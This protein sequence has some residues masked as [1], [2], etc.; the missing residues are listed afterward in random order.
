MN[1]ACPRRLGGHGGG[2][3]GAPAAASGSIGSSQRES[4]TTRHRQRCRQRGGKRQP[5]TDATNRVSGVFLQG[6]HVHLRAPPTCRP[7]I[8]ARILINRLVPAI[9]EEVLPE[10]RGFRANRHDRYGICAQIQE[11]CWKQNKGLYITFTDLTKAFG[12]IIQNGLWKILKKLG[13]PPKFLTMVRQLHDSQIGQVKYNSNLSGPFLISNGVN[14]GYVLAPTLF[15]IF[16]T[17]MLQQAS[18]NL[19]EGEEGVYICFLAD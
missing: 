9:A 1:G 16:F 18:D 15:T 11:K 6:L 19:E 2:K 10:T 12:T 7:C 4:Q 17:M 14:Q 5:P 3:W 13:C 8:L